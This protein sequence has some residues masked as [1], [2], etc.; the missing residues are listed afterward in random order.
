[1]VATTNLKLLG[2]P[3]LL[4]NNGQDAVDIYREHYHEIALILMDCMMPVMDG[5][6]AAEA[7]RAIEA[8]NGYPSSHI[9]ALT[10]SILDDDVKRCFSVGMDDY[11][12]KLFRKEIL[13]EKLEHQLSSKLAT[14]L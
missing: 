3:F 2:I 6:Q 13:T 12:P 1:M 10:A 14:S 11:L 5:F 4:A 9:I 7:I 8:E